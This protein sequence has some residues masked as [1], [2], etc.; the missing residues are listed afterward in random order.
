MGDEHGDNT[1]SIGGIEF[2]DAHLAAAA[3]GE[4]LHDLY[5][6]ANGLGWL[7]WDGTRWKRTPDREV[8]ER[9]RLWVV[10]CYGYA[11]REA[12]EAMRRGD[13][14]EAKRM[15]DLAR[16]WFRVCSRARLAAVVDLASGIQ[17]IL[18]DGTAFDARPDLLNCANGVVDLRTGQIR[19]HDP[20]LRFTRITSVDYDPAAEH[21]DWK[22]ALGA[23]PPEVAD[24]MQTRIGQAATGH[25]PDDDV[26]TVCQGSG[27][28]GKSTMITGLRRALGEFYTLVSDRVILAH[29]GDHPT[30]LMDLRG[31]RLAVIEELP[32]ERRLNVQRLKKITDAQINARL[33]AQNPITF[34]VT[35]SL[36]VTSNYR[37]AIEQT[38]H[39][40]WRRLALVRF[41]Y[42]F[43][44]E[45]GDPTLR[46]RIKRDSAVHRAV[47]AWIVAG[48]RRWYE[49]DQ[50][51]PKPP[52]QVADDTRDW[53]VGSDLALGYWLDRLVADRDSHVRS[54]ELL[55][56]F[57]QWLSPQKQ[58]EWS[59]RTFTERFGGHEETE[60]H[61]VEK[62]TIRQRPGLSRTPHHHSRAEAVPERYHAWVGVR[63]RSAGESDERMSDTSVKH[64]L[65]RDDTAGGTGGT[66][67]LDDSQTN[68]PREAA[69]S[70]PYHPYQEL[71]NKIVPTVDTAASTPIFA[72]PS[73]GDRP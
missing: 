54:A 58:V 73:R 42:T 14:T 60:R 47:L 22:Q 30:E 43:D 5:C 68:S 44:G 56:D 69:L 70:D 53:R 10:D 19:P 39:G 37:P 45:N 49:A 15:Q 6:W 29:P 50:V 16:D 62:R 41:P 18:Q 24:W 35:S 65:T 72:Q 38:D 32:E 2:S 20:G 4:V 66:G 63:F 12:A 34:D 55:A 46:D 27:A 26:V 1:F 59:E 61:H 40:T 57:N 48:A 31:V 17:G 9:I 51:M 8:R 21:R 71:D 11:T 25:R 13:K 7:R 36:L 28:N 52:R 64:P 3:V 23:L 33:I 67:H